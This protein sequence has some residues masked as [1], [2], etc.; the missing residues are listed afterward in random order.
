MD[1]GSKQIKTSLFSEQLWMHSNYFWEM[2]LGRCA[3]SASE[4][5]SFFF[6]F[7]NSRMVSTATVEFIS[8]RLSEWKTSQVK[9]CSLCFHHICSWSMLQVW[10][11]WFFLFLKYEHTSQFKNTFQLFI[12]SMFL[13][14]TMK[15]R[16]P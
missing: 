16:K 2:Q 15:R 5:D 10:W 9:W 4:L 7:F 14:L 8:K 11:G 6:F 1:H 13:S 3:P 12:W